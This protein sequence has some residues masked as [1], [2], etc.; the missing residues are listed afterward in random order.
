M[1][2]IRVLSAVA[3]LGAA[4]LGG[5]MLSAPSSAAF[6]TCYTEKNADYASLTTEEIRAG[7]QGTDFIEPLDVSVDDEFPGNRPFRSDDLAFH[8]LGR[9]RVNYTVGS[10]CANTRWFQT[11]GFI[12]GFR[13]F[14]GEENRNGQSNTSSRIEAFVSPFGFVGGATNNYTYFWEGRFQII[15]GQLGALFQMKQASNLDWVVHLRMD[16]KK[17]IYFL[18]RRYNPATNRYV[19]T[20]IPI[21]HVGS[22]PFNVRATYRNLDWTMTVTLPNGQTFTTS[23]KADWDREP[24]ALNQF[25]WGTYHDGYD[26]TNF[27]SKTP[28]AN[29]RVLVAGARYGRFQ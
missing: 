7:V 20:K 6:Q 23:G 9:T 14:E 16:D 29:S 1:D 22:R 8:T 15:D 5:T 21:A 13:L 24:T 4:G 3:V 28:S 26:G 17:N 18:N 2:K 19:T 10:E 27:G 12:Q 11:E 25:R